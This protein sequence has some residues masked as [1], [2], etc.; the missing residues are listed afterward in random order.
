MLGTA[1][2]G[3]P[4]ASNMDTSTVKGSVFRKQYWQRI[5]GGF[6]HFSTENDTK[7]LTVDLCQE[8][9]HTT[10]PALWGAPL[11]GVLARKSLRQD[12]RTRRPLL[13]TT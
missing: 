4:R 11:K 9:W 2:P 5:S 7:F 10:I 8:A 1:K 13:N 6:L 12:L 3:N